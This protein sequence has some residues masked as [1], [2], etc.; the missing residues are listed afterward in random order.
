MGGEL[1][2]RKEDRYAC[3]EIEKEIGNV[4]S[5]WVE[6]PNPVIYGIAQRPDGL[7]RGGFL[8]GKYF[9]DI[10]PVQGPDSLISND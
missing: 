4:I 8:G 3:Q 6:F 7:K 10:L 9:E 1:P 5:Y 2:D